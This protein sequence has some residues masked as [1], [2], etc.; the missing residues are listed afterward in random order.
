MSADRPLSKVTRQ[1]LYDLVWSTPGSKLSVDFGVS[2]VAIAKR[3]GKLGV[4]RPSR[5][6][7]AQIA[8]GHKPPRPP[9][10]ATPEELAAE[11]LKEPIPKTLSLPEVSEALHPVAD[12][13][14]KVVAAAKPDAQKRVSVRERTLPEVTVT[15][16]LAQR[17][18]QAFHVIL[19]GVEPRGIPF[20][21]AR[22]EYDRGYF[23][24]G[25]DRLYFKIEE[26]LVEKP[27]TPDGPRRRRAYWQSQ[28]ALHVPSERLTFSIGTE[29]YGSPK[30][31]QWTEGSE[32]PI[33]AILA[34]IVKEICRHYAE[35]QKRRVAEAIE[36]EKQR[37]EAEERW[38]KQQAEQAIRDQEEKK[39][40]HARA[41]EGVARTRKEDLMKAAEWWRLHRAME[42]FIAAAE[43]RW[44]NEPTG[45]L[46]PEQQAWLSWAREKSKELSP[47]SAGYPDPAKDL[48]VDVSTIPL[49]GPYPEQREF[50]RPPTMPEIPPPVVQSGY[51]GYGSQPSPQPYPFWLKYPRR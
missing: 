4:P 8:A 20:R 26:E 48:P 28:V 2:D 35:V 43:Q 46:T 18:A 13:L 5:G 15:K 23:E 45:E 29:R 39:Q 11:K 47:F 24:K 17:A 49:G 7:W 38:R 27:S 37:V 21:R 42:D 3:C 30:P 16:A 9:L 36:R 1:E 41:V 40:K 50:S 6:Y 32:N 19:K 22:S 25:H 51:T 12:E 34:E 14:A 44:R 31:K 10:P 33:D